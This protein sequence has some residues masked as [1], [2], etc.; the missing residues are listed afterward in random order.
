MNIF[1]DGRAPGRS[2]RPRQQ[3][4]PAGFPGAADIR[5]LL[6]RPLLREILP[7]RGGAGQSHSP[8][9][10]RGRENSRVRDKTRERGTA[11]AGQGEGKA[12][13]GQDMKTEDQ[14]A[15][16][17]TGEHTGWLGGAI[18]HRSRAGAGAPT[19]PAALHPRRLAAPSSGERSPY[20]EPCP[21]GPTS[22]FRNTSLT[23]CLLYGL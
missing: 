12:G 21:T 19:S 5:P 18:F 10:V 13:S 17:D 16:A 8:S 20:T 6:I 22:L 2:L 9:E 15:I 11:L 7:Q 14:C 3:Q 4:G 1:W 23:A